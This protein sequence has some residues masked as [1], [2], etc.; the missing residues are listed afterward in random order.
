LDELIIRVLTGDASAEESA[1][2]ARWRQEAPENE[3]RYQAVRRVW[4][5]TE[6]EPLSGAVDLSIV[7][8]VVQAAEERAA[9]TS[10]GRFLGQKTR[11]P[12]LRWALPLAAAT[13]AVSFGVYEWYGDS[14]P[15]FV[16]EASGGGTETFVLD[17]GSFVRLAMGS[18]LSQVGGVDERRFELRGR[19]F[20]AVAQD[21]ARPFVVVADGIEAR[22]LGTRFEVR[23]LNWRGQQI[24]VLEGRV[25]VRSEGGRVEVAAGEVTVADHEG[26]LTVSRAEDLLSLLDW[27]EGALLFQDT[28]LF[29]VARE[30][31]WRYGA[32]VEVEG[33]V[34]RQRRVTAW[35]GE[36]P[37]RDVVE[38][39][40]AATGA[41]CTVSDTLAVLR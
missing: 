37:F 17:D 35:Y 7:S 4:V 26:P 19:A 13:A 34:L 12:V 25:E 23:Q 2:L 33:A 20:F 28:P 10:R 14:A 41:S 18:R 15:A 11:G 22:V 24:A 8:A 6:S 5:A 16:L 21:L 38:S 3:A 39:L 40:C 30:V 36:E 31:G 9:E 32:R 27:E 1:Q 29:Q